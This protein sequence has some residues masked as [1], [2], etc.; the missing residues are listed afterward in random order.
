LRGAEIGDGAVVESG[1]VVSGRIADGTVVGG[2]PARPV[3]EP[4]LGEGHDVATVVM[5][6]FRLPK[7]PDPVDGPVE[8]A[9][10]DSLGTLHLLLALEDT[11]GIQLSSDD[12]AKA[13]SVA[14]L[15]KL[16]EFARRRP[17]N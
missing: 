11:F 8:I 17:S 3:T 7:L 2:V 9:Q 4:A 5:R 14:G 16:V 1:S 10:W 13:G 6:V 12:V 15:T